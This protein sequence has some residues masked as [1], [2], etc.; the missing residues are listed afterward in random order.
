[1]EHVIYATVVRVLSY[2]EGSGTVP[3]AQVELMDFIKQQHAVPAMLI[4]G[5]PYIMR[6]MSPYPTCI[7][8]YGDC[9]YSIDA[10]LKV[11]YGTMKASGKLPVT[12]N[13]KYTYGY[14]L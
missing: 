10:V 2:K 4:F 9:L 5:S 13:E 3:A 7:C 6:K 8:A 1:Y 11:L 12:V 14:G